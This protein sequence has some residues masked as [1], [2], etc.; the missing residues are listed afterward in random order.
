MVELPLI[1]STLPCESCGCGPECPC[2]E[3]C[4]ADC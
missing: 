2:E 3:G 4:D 1:E